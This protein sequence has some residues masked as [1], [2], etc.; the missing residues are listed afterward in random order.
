MTQDEQP[1]ALGRRTKE[2]LLGQRILMLDTALDDEI[3]A[4]L[5]AQIVTLSAQDPTTDVALWINSPGGS[6]SA[7]LAI[8]DTMNLV[9]NDVVTVALGMAYSAGQFLLTVG[10]PGRRYA[11]PHAQVLLHQG[12]AGI[13][14]SAPDIELQADVLR[15][16]R[17]TV[18]AITAER[19]GQSIER[20][21]EDSQRDHTFTAA[22]SL[23]YGFVDHV[24]D[25]LASVRPSPGRR[26]GLHPDKAAR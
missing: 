11:L 6:V 2:D 3:G 14:G 15:R 9:P 21:F 26:P 13:G 24:V 5:C 10:T 17:D 12:S 23:E 4:M 7:M 25:D 1:P 19:T 8:H 22:E 20:I 16:T 18:L